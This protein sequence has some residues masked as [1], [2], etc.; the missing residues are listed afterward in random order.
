MNRKNPGSLGWI[1]ISLLII[2][3]IIAAQ[4]SSSITKGGLIKVGIINPTSGSAGHMGEEIMNTLKLASTTST[5]LLYEDDQCDATKAISAYQKLKGEGAHVFIVS[6]SGSVL[7]LDPIAKKDGNLILTSYAD[8]SEIRKTGDEVIRFIPDALSIA[9]GMANYAAKLPATSTKIGLLYEDQDYAKSA[10]LILQQK[11]GKKIIEAEQYSANDTTFKTQITKL[12][13]NGIN[14]LLYVPTSDKAAKLVF[15]DIKTLGYTPF[16][17]GDVNTCE[18]PFSPKDFGLKSV[19]F[20]SGFTTETTAYKKFIAAYKQIYGQDSTAPFYNAITY[21]I[22]MLI[23]NF[24][25]THKQDVG[26]PDLKKYFLKGITGQMSRYSFS[27]NGEVVA[28][29]YLKMFSK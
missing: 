3:I 23:D 19:C 29:P 13:A 17:I 28:T 10:A 11:L 15:K 8:S 26:I 14:T 20:D 22:A 2:I 6:C 4:H 1:L 27:Q 25:K 7:A 5:T 18:Y 9:D 12:K 21:D 16:I 24:A